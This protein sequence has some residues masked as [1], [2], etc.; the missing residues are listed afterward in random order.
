MFDVERHLFGLTGP[1]PPPISMARRT[2]R[3]PR[4]VAIKPFASP[5][6]GSATLTDAQSST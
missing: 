5:F 6:E 4:R 1:P 2:P 3:T